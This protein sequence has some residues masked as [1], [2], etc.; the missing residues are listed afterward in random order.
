MPHMYH[1]LA[2]S[3]DRLKKENP[4]KKNPRLDLPKE[5]YKTKTKTEIKQ[6]KNIDTLRRYQKKKD[7]RKKI[8]ITL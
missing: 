2:S 1:M 4:E 6:S 8:K 7:K 5:R 3:A